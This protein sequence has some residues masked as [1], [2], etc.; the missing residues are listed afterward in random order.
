MIMTIDFVYG[1]KAF[2]DIA[3]RIGVRGIRTHMH[4]DIRN[5]EILIR[6]MTAVI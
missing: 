1:R 5:P 2:K 4:L 3:S 6:Y